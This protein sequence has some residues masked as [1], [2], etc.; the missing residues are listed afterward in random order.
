MNVDSPW[1]P[2]LQERPCAAG[3]EYHTFRPGTALMRKEV[4]VNYY[5]GLLVR[6]FAMIYRVHGAPA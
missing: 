1:S 4:F 5:S 3:C 2:L 6:D